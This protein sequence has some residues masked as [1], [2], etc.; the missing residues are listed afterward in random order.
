MFVSIIIVFLIGALELWGA[1]PAGFGFGLHPIVVGL[2]AGLG[3]ATGA[4]IAIFAGEG[5][6]K[7][8]LRG[9]KPEDLKGLTGAIVRKGIPAVGLLGPFLIGATVSA[10]IGAGIGMKR[11][12][13]VIWMLIGITLWT[14]I[15]TTLAAFG[16]SL[17][18]QG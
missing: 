7:L 15:L 3:S 11:R 12:P 14:V 4:I 1:I 5:V 8:F 18:P 13:L 16:V 6:R 2:A 9:K 17:L 10:A